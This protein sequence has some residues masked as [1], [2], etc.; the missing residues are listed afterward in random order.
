MSKVGWGFF[1]RRRK[2]TPELLARRGS[3][4]DY[5]SFLA[6]CKGLDVV[7]L[8]RQEFE[9]EFSAA[10]AAVSSQ[11][12]LSPDPISTGDHPDQEVTT[13]PGVER[14]PESVP[15]AVPQPKPEGLSQGSSQETAPSG[16][17]ASVASVDAEMTPSLHATVWLA[18]VDIEP[19]K[20]PP[21]SGST[22]LV[23]KIRKKS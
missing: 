23:K 15:D 18:G 2:I 11:G 9:S 3:V 8:E 10:L 20:P 21:T 19:T 13:L 17:G 22:P 1:S 5:D 4:F 6:Y 12:T 14:T 16:S 7:P